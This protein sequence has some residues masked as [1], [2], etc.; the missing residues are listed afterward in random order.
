MELSGRRSGFAS[1]VSWTTRVLL[2]HRQF[3]RSLPRLASGIQMPDGPT[4]RRA[5]DCS[6]CT[7]SRTVP[8]ACSSGSAPQT[9][10]RWPAPE[11]RDGTRGPLPTLP[12]N[13]TNALA[14]FGTVFHRGGLPIHVRPAETGPLPILQIPPD[15]PRISLLN[16]PVGHGGFLQNGG[17]A[18]RRWQAGPGSPAAISFAGILGTMGNLPP[19]SGSGEQVPLTYAG[20]RHLCA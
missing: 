20:V 11:S 4:R 14:I 13:V 9:R 3:Q 18:E 6:S 15:P 16:Q 8:N 1:A 7:G 12:G 17:A 2:A 10:R 19:Q 5:E